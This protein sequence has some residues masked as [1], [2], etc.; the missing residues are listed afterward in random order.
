METY[1]QTI[2]R[3]RAELAQQATQA[4]KTAKHN[5]ELLIE[6]S[7][8]NND[9]L[10]SQRVLAK[11]SA[12]LVR[13][14]RELQQ[15]QKMSQA[16]LGQIK[17]S[18]QALQDFASIAAHDLQAPLRKI[19]TFSTH[20]ALDKESAL[21]DEG[22]DYLARMQKATRH[23]RAFVTDLLALSRVTTQP[24]PLKQVDLARVAQEVVSDLEVQVQE[25]GGEVEFGALPSIEADELQMHQLLENLIGNALKFRRD[26]VP[27]VVTV[28]A[29]YVAPSSVELI[30]QD[31]GI[32]FDEKHLERIFA[33]F[34]RLHGRSRF[35][36]TGMGLAIC[37]KIAERHGG[38]ITARSVSGQGTAFITT[39]PTGSP[40]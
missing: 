9:L 16:L 10:T 18:N 39:L 5:N 28:A 12:E 36:G 38:S 19:E 13:V 7:R 37:R 40:E 24:L 30:V 26:G 27:P 4:Q 2:S 29:R 32:G 31:N 25:S 11:Q 20:L 15:E 22:R 1:E 21:S 3:L 33:P 6:L 8:I 14:N 34:Q 23:M 35:E 17:Q